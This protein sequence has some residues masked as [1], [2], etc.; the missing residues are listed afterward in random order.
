MLQTRLFQGETSFCAALFVRLLH[1]GVYW[2]SLIAA[3]AATIGEVTTGTNVYDRINIGQKRMRKNCLQYLV[4]K[5]DLI[6]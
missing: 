6:V 1:H 5:D 3:V 2:C 4:L